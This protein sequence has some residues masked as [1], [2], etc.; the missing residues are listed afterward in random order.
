M[1]GEHSNTLLQLR[2]KLQQLT[3]RDRVWENLLP[4]GGSKPV[5]GASGHE[6]LQLGLVLLATNS[7]LRTGTDKVVKTSKTHK[8]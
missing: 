8:D 4:P 7:R 2:L 3:Q 6:W 1:F 5:C